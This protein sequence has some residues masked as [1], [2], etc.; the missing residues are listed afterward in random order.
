MRV[1]YFPSLQP[2]RLSLTSG[3]RGTT[4]VAEELLC[5][6]AVSENGSKQCLLLSMQCGCLFW[7]HR[8]PSPRGPHL[9]PVCR[10]R[11]PAVLA[12]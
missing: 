1:R 7:G 9:L 6:I 2:E 3:V 11:E 5:T 8:H 10:Q 4:P 12:F